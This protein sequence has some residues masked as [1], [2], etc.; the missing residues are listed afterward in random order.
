MIQ[1]PFLSVDGIIKS[2]DKNNIFQ[3]IIFIKRKNPPYGIAL[4]GGFVD[5]GE[6]I[7]DAL[8][9]E[10]REEVSLDVTIES[11]LGVYSDPKRDPR[12]HT[13]S[14]VYICSSNGIPVASDDAKEVYIYKPEEF[15]YDDLVFDHSKIINDFLERTDL[16]ILKT[17]KNETK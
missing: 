4:P 1:T 7:E 8:R 10:M 9:R 3:G 13:A 15:P 12:F 14:V 6:T 2:Y 5:I 11:L 17:V 16:K